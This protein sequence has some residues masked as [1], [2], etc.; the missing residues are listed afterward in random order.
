MKKLL[1]AIVAIAVIL[2]MSIVFA[3]E[4]SAISAM[5]IIERPVY[6]VIS[7]NGKIIEINKNQVR[8][9][10]EGAYNEIVLHVQDSAYILNA[11]DGTQI[12]FK[13]LKS[14]DTVT[15]YYGPKVT[16]SIP[17]QGNAIALI[18]GTPNKGSAG[19]YMKVANLE[20]NQDGS[21]KVLCT[22]SDRLVT[23]RPEIFAHTSDIKEGSELVVWY[24]IMTMSMPGQATATKVV[25]LPV[26][27]DIKVHIG[28]GTIILNGRELAL[29]ENDILKTNGDTVMLPL[30]VIA[31]NLGY[32][33]VWNSDTRTVDLQNGSRTMATVTIGSKDYGKLK[34]AIRLDYAPEIVNGKTLVPVEFFTD[35]LNLKVDINNSHI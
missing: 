2:N 15:A 3:Q 7:T 30:G 10:G 11:E 17:P 16:K 4:I 26:K 12:P 31:E 24:D 22:N 6:N 21:I 5:P 14:G 29:S 35:V 33:V 34:M 9:L 20:H 23:I 13:D 28:A 25:L 1:S 27:A 32:D 8:V 19:M 18:V